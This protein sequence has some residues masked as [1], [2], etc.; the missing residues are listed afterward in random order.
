MCDHLRADLPLAAA[1]A[2]AVAAPRRVAGL[3]SII[4]IAEFNMPRLSMATRAEA[5]RD[6]FAHI[7]AFYEAPWAVRPWL[8]RTRSEIA[9][10]KSVL[11]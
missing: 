9:R 3:I 7:E 4:P 8:G 10:N 5:T 2:M 6:I 1:L 11:R